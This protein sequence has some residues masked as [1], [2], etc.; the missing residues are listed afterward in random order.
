MVG[1]DHTLPTYDPITR[2][3]AYHSFLENLALL[4][5]YDFKQIGLEDFGRPGNYF[6]RQISRWSKQYIAS[7][8]KDIPEM[9]KLMDWLPKNVPESASNSVVHG[10]YS[11]HNTMFD[12][13]S[14]KVVAVLDWELSTIGDP[15]G[16]LYYAIRPWYSPGEKIASMS[17]AERK[18]KNIPSMDEMVG[19]YCQF[20]NVPVITNHAFFQAYI[21]FR[22]AGILQ[23]IIGRVRDGTAADPNAAARAAMV[24]PLCK[25]GWDFV[26][27]MN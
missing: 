15:L 4:H 23:G 9:V 18:S 20:A 7:Q 13:K 27:K 2:G 24:E 1:Y 16:D 19:K 11:T 17:E 26:E 5:S 12:E 14:G 3:V 21:L 6:E 10:D 25:A 22:L 8:T